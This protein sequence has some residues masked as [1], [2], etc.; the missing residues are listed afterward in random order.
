MYGIYANI[1]GILMVN[2]T[3]YSIH[4]SY[5][6][7][8]YIPIYVCQ[9]YNNLNISELRWFWMILRRFPLP[10]CWP[11]DLPTIIWLTTGS[12]LWGCLR[13]GA[14]EENLS[15]LLQRFC[16]IWGNTWN[17]SQTKT[18][19]VWVAFL[20]VYWS[21]YGYLLSTSHAYQMSYM[22]VFARSFP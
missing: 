17:M 9:W 2:V 13:N 19:S 3:I 4:G 11:A 22:I 1:W 14:R 20:Q 15:Y 16:D 18:T 8:I 12:S 21:E 10:T 6:I 5:G 7:Y